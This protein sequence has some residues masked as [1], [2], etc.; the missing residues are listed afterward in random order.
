MDSNDN[1]DELLSRSEIDV[2]KVYFGDPIHVDEKIVIHQPTI[3]EIVEF[4][5][6]KF[7]YLANRLCAN[8]TSMRLELWD[9]GVDWTEI[10]DFDL[11]I[12]IIAT[13]DKEES[14]FIF[15]DLEFQMFRP[16]VI[17]DEEGNEKPILVY[18]PD[19]TI[20]IDEELYKKIV[21]Y[22][23]VMFN[24]HPKVEKAKGKITKEWMINEERIALE[25]EKKKR[26]DEKWMPSALFPLISSALNHPGFKYKKSELKDVHIFEFMDSIKRLQIYENTTALLKGMYSGMIDTKNIKEDQ[27]NWAKDIYNS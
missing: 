13:L 27:I 6:I 12:S 26:K 18:L 19:P 5:E 25:N 15:G 1:N 4:G 21:G 10:S 24:I 9:A 16:V 2:L 23:R 3:G 7:W 11:F 17:K 8:P 22:L 20:Q 14:S